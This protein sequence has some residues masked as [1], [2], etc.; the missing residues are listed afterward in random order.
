MNKENKMKS[1]IIGIIIVILLGLL[2]GYNLLNKNDN[3]LK[4]YIIETVKEDVRD[5]EKIEV[6]DVIFA[7]SIIEI[8]TIKFEIKKGKLYINNKFK[9]VDDDRAIS[10]TGYYYQPTG[11]YNIYVLTDDEEVYSL[12][13]VLETELLEYNF[14]EHE[15]DDIDKLILVDITLEDRMIG[16][17]PERNRVY[18]KI[19][20]ELV[21]IK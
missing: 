8:N 7:S 18:A 21:W 15:I 3:V 12:T 9:Y 17:L 5:G 16:Q 19:D 13:N 1:L 20:E 6:N 10:V 14:I 4:K 11:T 2:I